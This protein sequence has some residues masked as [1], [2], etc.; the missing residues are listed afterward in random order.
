MEFNSIIRSD[1]GNSVGSDWEQ[2]VALL[3][4]DDRDFCEDLKLLVEGCYLLE[5]VHTAMEARS[6][7]LSRTVNV[8]LLDVD[9]GEGEDGLEL[10]DQLQINYPE[11]PVIMI[12][13]DKSVKRVVDAMHRGADGYLGKRPTKA[14]LVTNL[15]LA[16]KARRSH[17]RAKSDRSSVQTEELIGSSAFIKRLRMDIERFAFFDST[18]MITGERG[19]GKKLTSRLIHS[20]SARRDEPFMVVNCA[21]FPGDLL[22]RQLFGYEQGAF[23]NAQKR[24]C[25]ILQEAGTGT[26]YLDGIS[27]MDLDCQT[28]L[29]RVLIDKSFK[30]IG[31][32]HRIPFQARLIV[33]S[34]RDLVKEMQK[35]RFRTDLYYRINVLKLDLAPLRERLED[36]EMLVHY[37]VQ[38]KS[39]DLKR[40]APA[41]ERDTMLLLQAQPWVGNIQELGNVI[42]N[43]LVH[44]NSPRLRVT[45]FQHLIQENYS[46][47]S[48]SEAKA[49]A[50]RLFQE[51]YISSVLKATEG[52]VVNAAKL[53]GVPRQTVHRLMRD[54]GISRRDFVK[55]RK[56]E[57]RN[58]TEDHKAAGSTD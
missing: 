56:A 10:L 46:G 32:Q 39:R 1:D 31:S 36:V 34:N 47:L 29:L 50:K 5:S 16:I 30:P 7:L 37:L 14:E 48:Y 51:R 26:I 3:V 4:D 33:G 49:Q 53:M 35:R 40:K 19:T 17:I 9:L 58:F 15:E 43:A 12:S 13:I 54:L 41:V 57:P 44:C 8:I 24:Q 25:G 42:E 2:K 21:A 27:E 22:E 23:Q 45:D 55:P 6:F 28:K 11:I 52:H 18:L 38:T 20:I